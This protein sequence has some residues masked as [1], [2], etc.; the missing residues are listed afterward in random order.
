MLL[1][2]A[3]LT[4]LL[5]QKKKLVMPTEYNSI[6][7]TFNIGCALDALFVLARGNWETNFAGVNLREYP[8]F[9]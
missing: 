8:I 7:Y 9:L 6:W 1:V 2:V 4:G 5:V 3:I